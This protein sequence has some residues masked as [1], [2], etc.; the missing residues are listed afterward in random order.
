MPEYLYRRHTVFEAL[1]G[2]RRQLERLW[3]QNGVRQSGSIRSLAEA[4]GIQVSTADK[5]VLNQLAGDGSH[6]GFVLEV[7]PYPYSSVEEMIAS[8]RKLD[9]SPF[10]L[11]LDLIHGPQNIGALLRTAEACGVHGVILQDRRSP[12][13]SA[14][15]VIYSAGAAE[16]LLMAKVT[17]LVRTINR[18]KDLDI[19]VVGLDLSDDAQTLGAVDLNMGI[20]LVVGH[21]GSGLRRLVRKSCD[22]LLRLPMRGQ[23]GSLNAAAAGSICLYA[24]WQARQFEGATK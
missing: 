18:L 7:G 13:I 16:H 4:R 10:L 22:I 6:Q 21:E 3:I 12:E 9:Q 15:V 19:W 23:V 14:R 2:K 20:A 8:A 5:H 11:M 17:N 1:R 24:A